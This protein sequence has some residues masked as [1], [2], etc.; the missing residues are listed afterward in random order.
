MKLIFFYGVDSM[1]ANSWEDTTSSFKAQIIGKLLG[2]GSIV[3]QKGRKP[4]FKF[5]HTETDYSWTNYCFKQLRKDIPLSPP[6]Y[7]KLIDK[8]LRK[9]Y[10]TR[11]YVQS[12]T[13]PVISYLHT[14]W[15]PSSKRVIPFHLLEYFFTAESLAWW[16]MDDGNL[17]ADNDTPRKIILST[18]SFSVEENHHLIFFLQQKF[19]LKFSL[20]AQNRLILYDSFQIHY[21]LYLIHPYIQQH[22]LYRKTRDH[23][24]IFQTISARRTTIYLPSDIPVNKP[25]QD[26]N[27]IL[28]HLSIMSSHFKKGRFYDN[29]LRCITTFVQDIDKKSFQIIINSENISNLEFLKQNT[30][31]HFSQLAF[32]CYQV[33]KKDSSIY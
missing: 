27:N 19:Q 28:S 1:L 16:Y 25:T 21:F 13:S 26:I 15:Y 17:T 32:L 6:K 10:S 12:K 5:N 23:S 33:M 18:D 11:Y 14:Y 30:G 31:L 7:S 2:D 4:R 3:K 29:Y 8:R 9:G 22:C 20:D 24:F